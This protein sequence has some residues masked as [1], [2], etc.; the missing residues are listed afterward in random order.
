[1]GKTSD[2][3]NNYSE[4]SEK[5]CL[6]WLLTKY[7]WSSQFKFVAYCEHVKRSDYFMDSYRKWY[8][9]KEGLLLF[10]YRNELTETLDEVG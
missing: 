10:K 7:H 5:E 3:I 1:M 2:E 9:T 8:P 6:L 4:E